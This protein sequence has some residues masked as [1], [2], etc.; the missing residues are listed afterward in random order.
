MRHRHVRDWCVHFVALAT[1]V[2][3]LGLAATPASAQA[4]N[5]PGVTKDSVSLGFISSETGAGATPRGTVQK[6]CKARIARQNAESGVNGRKIEVEYVDDQ[7]SGAN[8]TASQDLVQNR[9]VSGDD[10]LDQ[11][12]DQDSSFGWRCFA[13]QC[14]D[15]QLAE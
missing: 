7:T 13:P 12:V 8:L 9:K 4:T 2:A 15:V 11:V 3:T 5:A 14:V 6:S 1:G 10:G